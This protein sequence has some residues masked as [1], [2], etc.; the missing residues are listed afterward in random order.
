N[1]RGA[2]RPCLVPPTPEEGLSVPRPCP[3]RARARFRL[4]ALEERCCPVTIQFDYRLDTTGFFTPAVRA[5]MDQV[6][7]TLGDRYTDQLAAIT[8]G[9]GNTWTGIVFDPSGVNNSFS[10]TDLAVPANTVVIFAGSH[11]YGAGSPILAT[12]GPGDVASVS[13]S[14]A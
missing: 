9:S 5:A 12:G 13:G 7:H 6:A 3:P 4:E 10:F 8:P 14:A 2:C 11:S 1:P